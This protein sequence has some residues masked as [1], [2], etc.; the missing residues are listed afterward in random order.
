MTERS[1]VLRVMAVDCCEHTLAALH[2]L[3]AAQ[4]RSGNR[5]SLRNDVVVNLIVVGITQYPVRRFFLSELRR[6]YPTAPVMVLRRE[7]TGPDAVEE[8]VRGEFI[9]S[10][11]PENDDYEVVRLLRSIMPFPACQHLHKEYAY[12]IVRQVIRILSTQYSDPALDLNRVAKELPMSRKRLSRILNQQVGISFRQ[13][14]RDMRIEE[15]KRILTSRQFS[16]KEVALLVGF[17][18]SHYFSRSFKESTG[19]RAGE[20]QSRTQVF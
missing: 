6:V 14:L 18:D 10:D 2:K 1:A 15:A 12:N 3:P 8:S 19:L 4:I 11:L 9:L 5:A 16:V 13:L 7:T 17:S 20:Y